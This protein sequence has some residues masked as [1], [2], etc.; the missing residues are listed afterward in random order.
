MKRLFFGVAVAAI[1]LSASAFTNAKFATITYYNNGS[2]LYKLTTQPFTTC[3]E[4][5]NI[6]CR[7]EFPNTNNLDLTQVPASL[8]ITVPSQLSAIQAQLGTP[9]YST[10]KGAYQ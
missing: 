2:G 4:V 7:L 1:A 9:T 6:S 8:D 5:E 10:D 3:Q